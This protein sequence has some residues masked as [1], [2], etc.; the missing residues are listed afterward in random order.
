MAN[1]NANPSQ[2]EQ[3]RTVSKS[4]KEHTM[5]EQSMNLK[6]RRQLFIPI[7]EHA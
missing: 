3:W 7:K 4:Q 2:L 6:C 1:S 5:T